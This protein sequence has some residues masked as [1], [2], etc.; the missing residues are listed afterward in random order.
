MLVERQLVSDVGDSA[1][2]M[3]GVYIEKSAKNASRSARAEW[4]LPLGTEFVV[5]PTSAWNTNKF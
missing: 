2:V 3:L 1:F 5:V 4:D